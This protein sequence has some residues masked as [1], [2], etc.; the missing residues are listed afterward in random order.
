MDFFKLMQDITAAWCERH[1]IQTE[2]TPTPEARKRLAEAEREL[3]GYEAASV[4]AQMR[5]ILETNNREK[6]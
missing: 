5:E 1:G 2:R 4:D 3:Y 6:P